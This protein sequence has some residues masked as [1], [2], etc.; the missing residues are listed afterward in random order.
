M[1]PSWLRRCRVSL[2]ATTPKMFLRSID[3]TTTL[4]FPY[5]VNVMGFDTGLVITNSSE[6]TGSC[7][8]GYNGSNA[9]DDDLMSQPIAG[10][11]QWIK[12]LSG[13]ASGIPGL[14]HGNLRLSEWV[15]LCLRLQRL[16]WR[17]GHPG[18]GLSR[19]VHGGGSLRLGRPIA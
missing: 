6:E 4:L 7:T 17:A 14:Y 9:P 8:I 19:G 3:C 16:S 10:E 2:K 18:A 11:A 15:R 5:V 13:I 1:T 12:L